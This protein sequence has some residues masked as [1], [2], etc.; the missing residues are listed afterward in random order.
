M[1]LKNYI[2]W[3]RVCAGCG[4]QRHFRS[5]I[6]EVLLTSVSIWLWMIPP[7]R[8]SFMVGFVLL[9]YFCLVA[10]IDIEHHLILHP[11]SIF[12]VGL[13]FVTGVWLHGINATVLG[14]VA[15]FGIMLGLYIL[16]AW[17]LRLFAHLRNQILEDE[18]GLGFG[19]VNLCGV[20]GLILGWPGITGGIILAIIL[21]GLASLIYLVVM[22]ITGRYRSFMAIPYGPFLVISTIILL[23]FST[24]MLSIL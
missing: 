23:F 7:Q 8:M 18:E 20:L 9:A 1:G 22:L 21:G 16:G 15:G 24:S 17:I 4:R 11:V 19:D 12:G 5:W 10:I 6:V 14:G 2:L 3:P 13:G